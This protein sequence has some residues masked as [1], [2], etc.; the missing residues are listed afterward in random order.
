VT[1]EECDNLLDKCEP[2]PGA[3]EEASHRR[4]RLREQVEDD[5][6]LLRSHPDPDVSDLERKLLA[7]VEHHL[8]CDRSRLCEF[9]RIRDEV[10][11]DMHQQLGIAEH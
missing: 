1:A 8:G 10:V 9:K 3:P 7:L 11:N 2:K 6:L 4:I 5:F